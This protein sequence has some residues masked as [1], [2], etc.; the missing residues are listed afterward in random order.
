MSL[1]FNQKI[2]LDLTISRV[3]NVH[4]SQDDV[5]SRNILITLSDNGKP[6]SIPSEVSIF[7]KI[8]KPDNTYVY[9]DEDDVDHLFRNDDGTISII[10]S[11]QATCVP[12]ICE[13]ELQFITPKETISTRKFNIIVKKSVINDEEIESVIESN[14]IQKMIRHLTDFMNPHKVT[15]SQIGLGNVNNTSDTNKPV[16]TAQQKAI[17]TA[18]ANANAY[19]DQKIADLING[20]PETLDTLKE[21]ADAIESSKT[22]EEALNKAIGIKANKKPTELKNEDLNDYKGEDKLGNYYSG[23]GNNV[24]NKPTGIDAF[25]LEVNRVACGY[26]KQLLTGGNNK[27]GRVFVRVFDTQTWSVWKEFYSELNPQ[28]NI[29][30]NAATADNAKKV[31]GHSVNSDVPNNAVFTDTTYKNATITTDGLMSAEDKKTFERLKDG[32]VTGIKGNSEKEYRTG[33]VNLTAEN[34]GIKFANNLTT[35]EEGFLLDAR[36]GKALSDSISTLNSSLEWKLLSASSSTSTYAQITIP[37]NISELRI[38][39]TIMNEIFTLN[40][41][42]KTL[43]RETAHIRTGMSYDGKPS[44]INVNWSKTARTLQLLSAIYLGTDY[45]KTNSCGLYVEFR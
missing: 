1:V 42:V 29:S 34:I 16:S 15:K 17:D 31:N 5:D 32:S 41:V 11:E 35:T 28:I 27:S 30:G 4:C 44:M 19:A 26:Y 39:V 3:Q 9:I 38:T 36:Q 37:E 22:V 14:I 40:P 21:V 33:D 6:Y 45:A 18:Y 2:T 25:G 24:K 20:A 8:S 43:N 10:L 23:E 7:L 12:G 13:A